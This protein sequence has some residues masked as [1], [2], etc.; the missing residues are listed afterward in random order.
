MIAVRKGA[1]AGGIR[2][3]YFEWLVDLATGGDRKVAEAYGKLFRLLHGTEFL[4]ILEMDANRAVDGTDLRVSFVSEIGYGDETEDENRLYKVLAE[5]PCSLLEMMA[6]LSTRCEVHIMADPAVGNRTEKWFF[7]MLE[8][9]GLADMDDKHFD[10]KKATDILGKFM[11]R[12]YPPS[13]KGGLFTISDPTHNMRTAEIWY[14]MMWYLN[15]T[16]I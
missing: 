15:E 14:Q 2:E 9:L 6:A 11:R 10:E 5:D 12:E 16:D 3:E 8:S 7:G 13:G 4:Y 1:E